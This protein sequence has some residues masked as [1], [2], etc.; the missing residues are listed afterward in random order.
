M[1]GSP[2][3]PITGLIHADDTTGY[4]AQIVWNLGALH[5]RR[6]S[7]T[8]PYLL[9][10]QNK[11][12]EWLCYRAHENGKDLCQLCRVSKDK[13]FENKTTASFRTQ[14]RLIDAS[15]IKCTKCHQTGDYE[16]SRHGMWVLPPQDYMTLQ[17]QLIMQILPIP[18]TFI[19]TFQYT[20][21]TATF[22]QASCNTWLQSITTLS[23]CAMKII[24]CVC[25]SDTSPFGLQDKNST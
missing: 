17:S 5:M 24:Y 12:D 10:R 19:T 22:L 1:A 23:P 3:S 21:I 13:L 6:A 4:L 15:S 25:I 2:E 7:A 8:S 14:L 18:A 16:T 11:L 9:Q 20:P